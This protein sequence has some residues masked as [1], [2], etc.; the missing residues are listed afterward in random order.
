MGVRVEDEVAFRRAADGGPWVLSENAP[1]EIADIEK[2][3]QA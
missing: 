1:K 3:C 2:A